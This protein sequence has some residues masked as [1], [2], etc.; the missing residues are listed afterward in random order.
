MVTVLVWAMW[1]GCRVDDTDAPLVDA[2]WLCVDEGSLAVVVGVSGCAR[3]FEATCEATL[4]GS[5]VDV[6]SSH[7]D[8]GLQADC[9][10][11]ETDVLVSC[12]GAE[13]ADPSTAT[14]T[15]GDQEV[16]WSE[17]PAC[18]ADAAG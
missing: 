7:T 9:V 11:T 6:T 5:A 13:G 17:L 15:Y 1:G 2:G 18:E 16:P 3:A 12:P 4:V 8:G 10:S 14:V